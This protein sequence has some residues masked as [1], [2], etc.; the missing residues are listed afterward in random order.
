MIYLVLTV[1][2]ALTLTVVFERQFFSEQ[3]LKSKYSTIHALGLI[4]ASTIP[5]DSIG[6]YKLPCTAAIAMTVVMAAYNA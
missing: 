2:V 4:P 5:R 1:Q 3:I 6:W